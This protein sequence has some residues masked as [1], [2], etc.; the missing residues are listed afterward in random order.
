MSYK[1]GESA[2]VTAGINPAALSAGSANGIILDRFGFYDAIVHLKV[3]AVTGSPT[4]Q[5]VALKVQTGD[6]SDG[7]DFA[8][9]T[10]DAIAA[11]TAN[12]AEAELNLDLNPY[13]RYFRVVTTTT[14]TGGTTPAIPVAVSV[15][16]GSPRSIPA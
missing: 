12:S 7:S 15:V 10:G 11:L 6:Q 8:D 2:K 4:A 1:L 9:V 13:K 16:L 5:G 14:F 3:G